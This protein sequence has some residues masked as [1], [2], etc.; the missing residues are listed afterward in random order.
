MPYK[1]K[2]AL[3][4]A[5]A[6]YRKRKKAKVEKFHERRKQQLMDIEKILQKQ[7]AQIKDKPSADSY[8]CGYRDG[9]NWL[10]F[11]FLKPL[12]ESSL[13]PKIP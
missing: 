9:V 12:I 11:H 13:E 3:Y 7:L 4:A 1:D 8:Y 5:Q 6:R 10:Y 2:K